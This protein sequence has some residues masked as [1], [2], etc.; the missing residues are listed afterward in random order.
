MNLNFLKRS[1]HA[2]ITMGTALPLILILGFFTTIEHSRHRSTVLSRL[3]ALA[4]YSGQVIE[5]SL[6]H[7]MLESD[8]TEVQGILDTIGESGEFRVVYLLDPSGKVMFAPDNVGVGL[9]LDNHQPDCQPCHHLAVSHRPDSVVVQLDDGQHVF[10]SMQPIE[11]TPQC[12]RCHD[13]NERLLG[14]LLTDIPMAPM[15]TMLANDLRENLL[16]SAITV[17]VAIIIVNVAVSRLM[18]RRLSKMTAAMADLGHG[19]LLSHLSEGSPDEIGQLARAF[20][21]MAQQVQTRER[22]NR[23]LSEDLRHQSEQRRDLLKKLISAQEDERKRVAR[24]LHDRLGQFLAGLALQTG[25]LERLITQD[26]PRAIQQLGQIRALTTETTD[27]MY[28]LI[29]DLRPAV[30]DDLGLAAA[31]RAYSERLLDGTGITMEMSIGGLAERLS[32]EYETVL[33]RVYQEALVNIVRHAHATH[34][35]IMLACHAGVFE[36]Q[37]ID[38][39]QGFD[40]EHARPDGQSPHGLGLLGMQERLLQCRGHLE[41]ASQAGQG[42]RLSIFLPI[43]EDYCG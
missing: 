2:K 14:V 28:N 8:F 34:I 35:Q 38:D 39:G 27:R 19:E 40:P 24:E 30:L 7:A 17:L 33:Y 11:N 25:A 26:T 43:A 21:H 5:S 32:P 31:L 1:L 13:P 10:R 41:I 16:W 42:T 37:I 18:L 3:S 12:A 22:E 6:Q 4:S 36:G 20:N 23:I 29:L 9:V 15:E